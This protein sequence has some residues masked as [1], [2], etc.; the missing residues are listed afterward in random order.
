MKAISRPQ[1]I[2]T[3]PIINRSFKGNTDTINSCIFSPN[4]Y[5]KK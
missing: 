5:D 1:S 4:L 3:D 2:F